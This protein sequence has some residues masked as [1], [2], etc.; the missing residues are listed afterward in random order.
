MMC[1]YLMV[2]SASKP[3][4][5]ICKALWKDHSVFSG[6]SF[7]TQQTFNTETEKVVVSTQNKLSSKTQ[8]VKSD[9]DEDA[10]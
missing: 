9:E 3:V 1:V 8:T 4:T 7:N 2:T 10:V 6:A 5:F